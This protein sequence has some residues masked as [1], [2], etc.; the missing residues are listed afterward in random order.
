MAEQKR[1]GNKI[2]TDLENG[3]TKIEGN[4]VFTGKPYSCEVP[5]A[6]LLRYLGGDLI[7]DAMPNTSADDR[8]F[9]IS[10]ISPEGWKEQ[11]GE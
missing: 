8:E 7:Q 11:F 10:G 1:I 5:T 9:L 3:M 4:C 6:G 2:A